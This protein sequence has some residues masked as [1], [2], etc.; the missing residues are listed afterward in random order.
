MARAVP[1]HVIPGVR[2]LVPLN[3]EDRRMMAE[4][5]GV[6]RPPGSQGHDPWSALVLASGS[7]ADAAQ[8][9]IRQAVCEAEPGLSGSDPLVVLDVPRSETALESVLSHV[10]A[11]L[12]DLC[13]KHDYRQLLCV[14]RL[15]SGLPVFR[16][17]E[18]IGY[19]RLRTASADRW[20][21][22]RANRNLEDDFLRIGGDHYSLGMAPITLMR[23]AVVINVLAKFH[24]RIVK[25]KMVF[26][27]MRSVSSKNR[28][29]GP[30]LRLGAE[31]RVGWEFGTARLMAAANLFVYRHD[32]HGTALT[33]WGMIEVPAEDNPLALACDLSEEVTDAPYGGGPLFVPEPLRLDVLLE[34]GE[35]FRALFEREAGM[36]VEHLWAV[37]RG[38]GR[39]G[40]EVA[41]AKNGELAIWAGL[42][43]TLPMA[44]ED[45]R[46]GSLL[47]AAREE[48]TRTAG[49]I[50]SMQSLEE[51]VVRF[52][53]LAS[54]SGPLAREEEDRAT[55]GTDAVRIPTY[56]F[57]I[58]GEEGHELWLVDYFS[59]LSFFQ[60]LIGRLE[61]SSSKKTTGLRDS[62]AFTKT[63]I[64]D[65]HLA[66]MLGAVPGVK[67]ALTK[68]RDP[69]TPWLPNAKFRFG[70]KNREIDV[71]MRV[72]KVLLAVQTWTP[73]AD[74]RIE[75]GNGKA[76]SRRWDKI[77]GKL[78]KTD[79][80]YTDY[81]LRHPEGQRLMRE[82]G[83]QHVLP[84][85]CGPHPEPAASYETG[86]WLRQPS[87]DSAGQLRPPPP[88][89]RIA[90]PPELAYF[91]Y[92]ATEED[93]R[94]ICLANKWSLEDGAL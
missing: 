16:S 77:K 38:L 93:L 4:L 50:Q 78:D 86:F 12:G 20:V 14:S 31:G 37:S 82:E 68:H 87:H 7:A 62:D 83:F 3:E 41:E 11:A 92:T 64:F 52:V 8:D 61:F 47:N 13:A 94:L 45:L 6:G 26:N 27:F 40:T 5:F 76:M 49:P 81:L 9:I 44:R 54:S 36:P 79:E 66:G 72:G 69:D 21:L 75:A 91:F 88:V 51:S 28:L 30:K 74:P 90:T 48:L 33:R 70:G 85:V 2:S 59:T 19:S 58:H 32:S 1:N 65:S 35:V 24:A 89:P 53:E 67:E 57:M 10:E 29:P 55:A 71:P 43:G 60:G 34:Q 25:E 80:R 46:G 42:T 23:D 15:C 17:S 56:P 63:S 22:R 18:D 39:L 73:E 84:I